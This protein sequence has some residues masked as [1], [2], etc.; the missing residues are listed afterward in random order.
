MMFAARWWSEY[1]NV[2][3]S[4]S[5]DKTQPTDCDIDK[6]MGIEKGIEIEQEL[7]DSVSYRWQQQPSTPVPLQPKVAHSDSKG[8]RVRCSC[9]S[10]KVMIMRLKTECGDKFI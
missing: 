8:K 10:E 5:I 4:P 2:S 6:G 7:P 9:G 1:Y 3:Q